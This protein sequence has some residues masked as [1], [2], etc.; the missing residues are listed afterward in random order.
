[1]SPPPTRETVLQ[2]KKDAHAVVLKSRDTLTD[3][4]FEAV[5]NT[6]FHRDR[7]IFLT[8]DVQSDPTTIEVINRPELNKLPCSMN[9]SLFSRSFMA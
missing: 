8:D 2:L 4:F 6:T 7:I 3:R 1:M 5:T 9:F